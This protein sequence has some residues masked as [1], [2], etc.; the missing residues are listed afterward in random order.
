MSNYKVINTEKQ[1]FLVT[2]E[3]GFEGLIASHTAQMGLLF[4]SLIGSMMREDVKAGKGFED[5][6]RHLRIELTDLPV[7][8]EVQPL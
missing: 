2:N 8:L 3:E 5:P 7:N 6:K 1:V 4:Q